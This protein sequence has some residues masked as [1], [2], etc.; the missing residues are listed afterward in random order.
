LLLPVVTPVLVA[1]VEGTRFALQGEPW[2]ELVPPLTMLAA[3]DVVFLGLC[4]F[5]FEYVME[6]MAA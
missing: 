5:L 1:A 3:F 4:P 2:S 6:E